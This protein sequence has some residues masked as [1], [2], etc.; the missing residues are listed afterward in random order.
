MVRGCKLTLSSRLTQNPKPEDS[1]AEV[2]WDLS[3]LNCT[4]SWDVRTA[5]IASSNI[6]Q[7]K[8]A[9]AGSCAREVVNIV[10]GCSFLRQSNA[11]L[12]FT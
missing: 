11:Y 8:D 2:R 10:S 5:Q 6:I 7:T 9:T 4:L 1:D 3:F 12:H